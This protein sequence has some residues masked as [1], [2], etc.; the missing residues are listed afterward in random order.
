M[1]LQRTPRHRLAALGFA[2]MALAL[3]AAMAGTPASAA[4]AEGEIRGADAPNVIA[5]SYI[6]VFKD[7]AVARTG[8]GKAAHDLT[9]RHGGLVKRTY[10]AALR[11]FEISANATTAARIAAHP[12][13]RFV[14]ANMTVH[15]SGTQT[16]PP[17]WGLDRIDQRALP[18]NNTYV[19]PNVASGVRAYII[20]TGIRTTHT[21]FEG[22]ATSGFDAIDGG[23]A[24]DC[25]GHGTHVAG[26]VGGEAYGVAKDVSLI[27]VRVLNCQGSGTNAQ[28][29]AGIDY[30][31][32]NHQ[33]GQ[34]AVANMSLGGSANSSIDTAVTN[35][36]ADGVTYAVASG[37]GDIFGNRQDACGFSPARVPSAIT[38][39]ATQSN[40]AAASFSNFGTCVDILAPGVSITSSWAASDTATN[41][42]SGTSMATPHVAG[43]AALTLS[44]NPA[45]TPQQVRDH[46][47]NN[48]TTGAISNVGTGTPNRLLFVGGG[49]TPV[50]D[51]SISVSPASGSVTAG[52]ST[53]ATVSTATTSGSAQTVNL[54]AGVRAVRQ[55]VHR[56]VLDVDHHAVRN[57]PRDGHRHRDLGHARHHVQ[58]DRHRRNRR[59]LQRHQRHEREH[60]RHR[61]QRQQP[62][63]DLRMRSRPVDGQHHRGPH[64]PHLP[65][66]PGHQPDRA[67]RHGVPAEELQLLR[68][69][70][71]RAR[72]VH[73]EPIQRNG[74]RHLAAAGA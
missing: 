50:N 74:E 30:V 32:G 9:A 3:A 12:S 63:H 71:Q 26:T 60:P 11:G 41:T 7:G 61:R 31:T 69:R 34:P 23:A 14:E 33:A 28:V 16:N 66:R 58:P 19:Y 8:V 46:L 56:D 48:A 17:S 27:A 68:Q 45:W 57:V 5:G 70:G 21:T 40:D 18:L 24:D 37:N 65:G 15:V 2:T 22:R 53:A 42:I 44:A 67:G 39:G 43:A 49:G 13:V 55:L 36:I 52:G 1:T 72:D 54:S 6:V 73:P 64:H 59:W 51:F 25:H 20:D 35:S 10:V 4:P 47:V 38:V 29:V 62:D